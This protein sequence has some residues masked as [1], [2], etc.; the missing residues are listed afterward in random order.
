M[1]DHC[2][3]EVGR[4]PTVTATTSTYSRPTTALAANMPHSRS[5]L[6]E[7]TSSPIVAT[8]VTPPKEMNT[9]PAPASRLFQPWGNSFG[10]NRAPSI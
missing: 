9:M 1:G 10:P 8:L 6:G 2:S 4:S 7:R 3:A 5:R